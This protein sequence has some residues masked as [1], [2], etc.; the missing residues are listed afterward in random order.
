MRV[1][2]IHTR[3]QKMPLVAECATL[4]Q[5]APIGWFR[6]FWNRGLLPKM[7]SA[8][9]VTFCTQPPRHTS[10]HMFVNDT[11]SSQS[12]A[13]Q[14][15]AQRTVLKANQKPMMAPTAALFVTTLFGCVS[16]NTAASESEGISIS[17]VGGTLIC[18]TATH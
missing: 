4:F 13:V 14:S 16:Q 11:P 18:S 1:H 12:E 15:P 8:M 2:S 5:L 6:S 7:L 3:S 17:A 10:L 9:P